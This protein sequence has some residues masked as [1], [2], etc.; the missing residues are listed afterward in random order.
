MIDELLKEINLSTE[1]IVLLYKRSC[2][3]WLAKAQIS[4]DKEKDNKWSDFLKSAVKAFQVGIE[5]LK[6]D[7][8]N[9]VK[10]T[11]KRT[12]YYNACCTYSVQSEYN[13]N[14]TE[15]IKEKVIEYLKEIQKFDYEGTEISDLLKDDDFYYIAEN[16]MDM[17]K[18]EILT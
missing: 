18:K 6:R 17:I 2:G 11:V 14:I 3:T 12:L 1:E 9:Y 16:C 8:E 7:V 5:Y 15:E 13:G 4:Y 10:P